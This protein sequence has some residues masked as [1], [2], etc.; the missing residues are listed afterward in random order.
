[1][2][3]DLVLN[4]SY[5]PIEG[6]LFEKPTPDEFINYHAVGSQFAVSDGLDMR[7]RMFTSPVARNPS[8]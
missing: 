6:E 2:A 7:L 1:M 5:I 4:E 3:Y 8:D